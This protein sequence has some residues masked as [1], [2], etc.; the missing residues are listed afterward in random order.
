MFNKYAFKYESK[1]L[2]S[3]KYPTKKKQEVFLA[4]SKWIQT[5]HEVNKIAEQGEFKLINKRI[6]KL[7]EEYGVIEET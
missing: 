7:L 1:D 2:D 5:F 4:H 3:G 6:R